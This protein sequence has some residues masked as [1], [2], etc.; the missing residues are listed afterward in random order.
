MTEHRKGFHLREATFP[1]NFLASQK[2]QISVTISLTRIKWLTERGT[3]EKDLNNVIV[4][5]KTGRLAIL[6][7]VKLYDND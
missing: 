4:P 1:A 5:A 6:L 2:F 7:I 3:P